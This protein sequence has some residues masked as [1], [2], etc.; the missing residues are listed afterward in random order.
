SRL[1]L[2]SPDGRWLATLGAD[3]RL[4]EVGPWRLVCSARMP[5]SNLPLAGIAF[6]PDSKIL[7]FGRIGDDVQLVSPE[8]GLPVAKLKAPFSVQFSA[9]R[10]SCGGSKL[11]AAD[12]LSKIRRWDFRLTPQQLQ[13][14]NLDWASPPSP[15]H[16]AIPAG[17]ITVT[18][19]PEGML[20]R[21]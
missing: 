1:V 19:P 14:M 13:A 5:V 17:Q 4:W 20:P 9:I 8:T 7:A 10:L 21:K 12:P 18:V 16:T 15:P 6:S 2:F 11:F 3:Y